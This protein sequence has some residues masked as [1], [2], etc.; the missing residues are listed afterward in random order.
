MENMEKMLNDSPVK[1]FQSLMYS[2]PILLVVKGFPNLLPRCMTMFVQRLPSALCSVWYC[3]AVWSGVS[4]STSK[5]SNPGEEPP[6][7]CKFL[8][9]KREKL[10]IYCVNWQF[11]V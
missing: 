5:H 1:S 4:C 9:I 7:R 2:D 6:R 11:T 3:C 10:A 8:Q